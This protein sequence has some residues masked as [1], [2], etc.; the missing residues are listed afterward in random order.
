MESRRE[1]QR[2][3]DEANKRAEKFGPVGPTPLSHPKPVVVKELPKVPETRPE[4]FDKPLLTIDEERDATERLLGL[5]VLK[6][7]LAKALAGKIPVRYQL[8]GL[9]AGGIGG[10]LL[11]VGMLMFRGCGG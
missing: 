10:I 11:G 8:K 3:I 1:Y 6:N 2:R 7:E 5:Q 9:L 4:S